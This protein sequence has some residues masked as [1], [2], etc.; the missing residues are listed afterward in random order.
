MGHLAS[1][2]IIT[3]CAGWQA[4]GTGLGASRGGVLVCK[5]IK[6]PCGTNRKEKME[7]DRLYRAPVEIAAAISDDD[8][9][10]DGFL[11]TVDG[12]MIGCSNTLPI[13]FRSIAGSRFFS[14]VFSLDSR[15]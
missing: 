1:S 15:D 5:N 4:L 8:D 7:T 10:D 11:R 2:R 13:G 12:A 3:L 6:V 14:S 9:D